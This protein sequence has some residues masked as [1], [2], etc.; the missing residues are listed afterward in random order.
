MDADVRRAPGAYFVRMDSTG[1]PSLTAWAMGTDAIPRRKRCDDVFVWR[2]DGLPGV[3]VLR[4]SYGAQDFSPHA[5]DAYLIGLIEDGVHSVWCRGVHNLAAAGTI[6]TMNPGEVHHGGAGDAHGW[7]Q[8]MIYV[9]EAAV[10][11]IAR[12]ALDRGSLAAPT[13]ARCFR[14]DTAV[15]ASFA[16]LHELTGASEPL[17]RQ[18]AF[19][20]LVL[21]V[22]RRHGE[23]RRPL[24]PTAANDAAIA[25]ARDF[26]HANRSRP[27]TL[28]ELAAVARLRRRQLIELFK[29][30]TGLPPHRYLVQ[31][32]VEAAKRLLAQGLPAAEVAAAVGF[33]DQSHLIRHFRAIVGTTPARYG[34]APAP[35]FPS[36]HR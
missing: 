17:S 6:A 26:L 23:F 36:I 13:F 35:H 10:T 3:E 29:R 25:R 1:A 20:T 16:A 31:L 8:R 24:S 19:E 11:E 32:R 14:P 22:L 30:R 5:H 12:D 33:A 28:H 18:T 21:A 9:P 7:R 4:A 34:R 27:V 2:P 15:A